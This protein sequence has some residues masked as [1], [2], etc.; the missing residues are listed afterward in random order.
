MSAAFFTFAYNAA[1]TL[2]RTIESVINQSKTNWVYYL[3]DDGSTADNT[4][5]IIE[6]YAAKD[7]RIIPIYMDENDP[8]EASR[9]GFSKIFTS[10]AEYFCMLDADDTYDYKFLE[11]TLK[12]MRR[13]NLDI[14][15]V[16][17]TFIDAKTNMPVGRRETKT[18]ILLT[19]PQS[20][21]DNF[22]QAHQFMR[23]IWGKVYKTSLFQ[24]FDYLSPNWEY[25][26]TPYG[27]DTILFMKAAS[28][29]ERVGF[30]NGVYHNYLVSPKS[31]SYRWY[32]GR[33]TADAMLYDY[34]EKFLT[35]KAGQISE[36][37]R[38]FLN[39]VYM[40]A[41][42]DTIN[43]LLNS[44]SGD[45]F[46][47]KILY[48]LLNEKYSLNAFENKAFNTRDFLM[49]VYNAVKTAPPMFTDDYGI[50]IG[51]FLSGKLNYDDDY[52]AYSMA[53][54]KNLMQN[55]NIN[56]AQNLMNEWDKALKGE[57]TVQE[58]REKIKIAEPI[59]A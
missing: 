10:D 29:A 24:N 13:E 1:K 44:G 26:K 17:S 38:N 37:N 55:G 58:L 47:L 43:T 46:I 12:F 57:Q 3:I 19:D 34:A 53:Y 41:L 11:K 35:K 4:R 25:Y 52:S 7:S 42:S 14:A 40:N 30:L 22:A 18:P 9:I 32:E 15:G 16:G 27:G 31:A 50:W 21:N 33:E 49:S 2:P 5:E 28:Y 48:K 8:H 20:Y 45:Q 59:E 6:K 51:L 23:T 36:G 56:E 54:I 39:A